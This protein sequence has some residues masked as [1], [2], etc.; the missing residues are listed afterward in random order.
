MSF[1]IHPVVVKELLYFDDA[2]LQIG[3]LLI[4]VRLKV[5]ELLLQHFHLL[6]GLIQQGA[7]RRLAAL[8][9]LA[10]LILD[11]FDPFLLRRTQ[12]RHRCYPI[13]CVVVLFGILISSS[14]PL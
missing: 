9:N 11:L 6:L 5:L 7:L 14:F 12:K 13:T 8:L 10:Q 3:G 1:S 2:L 4:Q